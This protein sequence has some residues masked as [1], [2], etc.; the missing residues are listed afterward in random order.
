M[1]SHRS[2]RPRPETAPRMKP[3]CIQTRRSGQW[4]HRLL[5]VQKSVHGSTS[6]TMPSSKQKITYTIMNRRCSQTGSTVADSAGGGS[7]KFS[8]LAGVV[9][10][11]RVVL[12]AEPEFQRLQSGFQ[13]FDAG[14]DVAKI[15]VRAVN[16]HE[17]RQRRLSI[18]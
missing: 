15:D 2:S 9:F 8:K 17:V 7:C 13:R 1:P 16:L 4:A 10:K 11:M 18:A 14:G 5:P 6:S 12:R 3:C